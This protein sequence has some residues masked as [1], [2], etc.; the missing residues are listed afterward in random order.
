MAGQPSCKPSWLIQTSLLCLLLGFCLMETP[1]IAECR[2]VKSALFRILAGKHN[3]SPQLDA[4]AEV[5]SSSAQQQRSSGV[6]SW[7]K[8]LG[9]A[10]AKWSDVEQL[11]LLRRAS[12]NGEMLSERLR[13]LQSQLNRHVSNMP[14]MD[15]DAT[16]N[17]IATQRRLLSE[18]K[19]RLLRRKALK[20]NEVALARAKKVQTLRS[21]AVYAKWGTKQKQRPKKSVITGKR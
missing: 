7:T 15:A 6:T 21:R 5:A 18:R 16:A 13:V 14:Q 4:A 8:K 2:V 1:T 19:W 9:S 10:F 11:R 20:E 3:P 17:A 12:D